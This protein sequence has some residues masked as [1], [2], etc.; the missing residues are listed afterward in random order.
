MLSIFVFSFRFANFLLVLSGLFRLTPVY[1][2]RTGGMAVKTEIF[3]KK[4]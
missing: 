4:F 1:T 3:I 2:H